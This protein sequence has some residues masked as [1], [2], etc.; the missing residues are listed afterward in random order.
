MEE[1]VLFAWIRSEMSSST[2]IPDIEVEEAPLVFYIDHVAFP[3]VN[4][5]P[6][7]A[8][9]VLTLTFNVSVRM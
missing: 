3:G 9:K 2:S 5:R 4:Y 6:I 8:A 1:T 7:S